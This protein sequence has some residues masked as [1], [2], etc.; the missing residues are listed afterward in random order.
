MRRSRESRVVQTLLALRCSALSSVRP[1][2]PIANV[3]RTDAANTSIDNDLQTRSVLLR[4]S[5]L[6]QNGYGCI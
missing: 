1:C 2:F 6:S 5:V 4:K 3:F